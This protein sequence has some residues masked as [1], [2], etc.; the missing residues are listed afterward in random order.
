MIKRK[1]YAKINLALDVLGTLP[2]GYHEVAMVMQTVD[3]F[4]ELNFESFSASG[5]KPEDRIRL[6]LSMGKTKNADK[7]SGGIGADKDNIVYKA[8]LAMLDRMPEGKGIEIS[9]K[10]N[11]PI[12]AGMA[13]GST[14]AAATLR[15]IN[16]LFELGLTDEDLCSI[17]VKL[18]ADVPYCIVGGTCLAEGIGER[19]TKLP[20]LPRLNLV[21][22]KPEA[23][24]STKTVYTE[25][26]KVIDK[27]KHPDVKAMTEAVKAGDKAEIAGQLGNILEA[28]TIPACPEIGEIKILLAEAGAEGVL[29]SGSGPTV[30][31]IFKDK[32]GAEWGAEVLKAGSPATFIAVTETV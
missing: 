31:G 15:G 14:D 7:K 25:L 21:I 17:G 18:G 2:N 29:M 23:G 22:A 27:A 4:D 28:V 1:A 9:L 13:G 19:L 12:A 30:F 32:D 11:I 24:V 6:S 26:D 10:K 3:L 5:E 8:A 20:D 16:E